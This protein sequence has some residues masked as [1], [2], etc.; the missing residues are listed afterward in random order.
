MMQIVEGHPLTGSPNNNVFAIMTI[1]A[2]KATKHIMIPKIVAIERGRVVNA[3][4]PSIA[5]LNNFQQAHLL[6]P[7]ILS[8]LSYSIHYVSKPTKLNNPFEYL[9]YSFKETMASTA[10]LDI[11]R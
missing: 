9:L 6:S 1:M 4:I 2:I 5:Y 10:C 3:T 11:K 8:T 7:A